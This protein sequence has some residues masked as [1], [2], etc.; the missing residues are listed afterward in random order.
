MMTKKTVSDIKAELGLLAVQAT[1]KSSK[2]K[3]TVRQDAAELEKT[4]FKKLAELERE[5]KKSRKPKARRTA[6]H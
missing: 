3:P 4:L 6:K 2:A 5:L 1:G